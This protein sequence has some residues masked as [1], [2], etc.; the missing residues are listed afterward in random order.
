MF[1]IDDTTAVLS[2]NSII[3]FYSDGKIEF[4]PTSEWKKS[5]AGFYFYKSKEHAVKIWSCIN[6][7]LTL[8]NEKVHGEAAN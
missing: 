7:T 4:F 3:N 1:W 6:E 8:I 5:A 2:D